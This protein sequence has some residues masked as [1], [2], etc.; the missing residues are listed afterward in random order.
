MCES[1]IIC[2]Q[3]HTHIIIYIHVKLRKYYTHNIIYHL[4]IHLFDL[5]LKILSLLA[6]NPGHHIKA[7]GMSTAPRADL[8]EVLMCEARFGKG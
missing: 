1:Y 6:K 5:T 3:Y 2:T 7:A 8:Q 4:L